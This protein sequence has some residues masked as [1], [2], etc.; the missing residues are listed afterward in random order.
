MTHG[1]NLDDPL[2][3]EG[4]IGDGCGGGRLFFIDSSQL[5]SYDPI[6]KESLLLLEELDGAKRV[7]KKRC[8]IFIELQDEVVEFDLSLL[9]KV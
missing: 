3:C 4:V 8:S 6:T 2:V 1:F 7:S 5:K 9:Q